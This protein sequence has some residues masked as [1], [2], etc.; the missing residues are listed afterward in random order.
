[1]KYA[2]TTAAA[3]FPTLALAHAGDHSA[4]SIGAQI[5]H[6]LTEPDHAIAIAALAAITVGAWVYVRRN[7]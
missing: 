6:A 4:K 5:A 1:M 7:R 3:L 2:F